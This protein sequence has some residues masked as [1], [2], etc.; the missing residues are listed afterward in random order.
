M[1]VYGIGGDEVELENAH[2]CFE[3]NIMEMISKANQ[4]R[5]RAQGNYIYYVRT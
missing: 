3:D 2:I 4:A 5:E 1:L